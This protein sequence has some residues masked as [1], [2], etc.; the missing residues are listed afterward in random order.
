MS[1]IEHALGMVS[2][3]RLYNHLLVLE[4]VRHP[5][6]SYKAL[7]QTG[8]YIG[9]DFKQFGLEVEKHPFVKGFKH[10][11][12]NIIGYLHPETKDN[13]SMLVTSHY[14]TVYSTPEQMTI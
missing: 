1:T 11:F 8:E 7:I 4:G 12:F 2:I 10:P 13:S 3:E 9:T 14:Y 6:D 5:L